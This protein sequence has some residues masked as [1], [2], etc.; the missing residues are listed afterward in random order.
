M[1]HVLRDIY[2]VVVGVAPL[3]VTRNLKTFRRL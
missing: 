1:N 3:L 2:V